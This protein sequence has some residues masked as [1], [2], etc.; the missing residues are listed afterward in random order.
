VNVAQG[1]ML[2]LDDKDMSLSEII[3]RL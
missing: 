3:L 2:Y 1:S